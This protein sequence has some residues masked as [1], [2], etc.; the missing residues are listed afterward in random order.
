M[1]LATSDLNQRGKS[2]GERRTATT[3]SNVGCPNFPRM[4]NKASCIS[5]EKGGISSPITT[6]MF[7]L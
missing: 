5:W 7:C 6:R 2:S 4:L 3:P 1:N